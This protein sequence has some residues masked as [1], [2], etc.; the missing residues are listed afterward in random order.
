M[1]HKMFLD[2]FFEVVFV[3]LDLAFYEPL[4]LV[5]FHGKY[6]AHGSLRLSYE[7]IFAQDGR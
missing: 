5:V 3:D 6:V 1:A 7:E 2:D 4:V